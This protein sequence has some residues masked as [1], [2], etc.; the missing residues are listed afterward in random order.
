M[1]GAS[2]FQDL[3][4]TGHVRKEAD[5]DLI[6]IGERVG[7][8]IAIAFIVFFAALLYYL[9]G[10]GY[11]FSPEFSDVDA[12]L[13]YG[14]ILFGIVPNI[15]R[16]IT[17]RRN[18]GRLFDII[19]GLLFLV[20]GT[21]FLTKFPFHFNDL[22]TILPDDIQDLFSWFNDAVFRLLFQIAL[23]ITALSAVYQSV[24]YV[25]VRSELRRRASGGSG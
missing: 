12:V 21:Y 6:G 1:S 11:I 9:Q 4:W 14:V 2:T 7:N 17:G 22:Y 15:V 16:A 8:A 23:I 10:R 18:L 20:V 19:N 24:M 3:P 13:L 25:L 5:K